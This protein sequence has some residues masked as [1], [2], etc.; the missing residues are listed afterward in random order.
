M[1]NGRRRQGTA[2]LPAWDLDL[3]L[4]QRVHAIL[5]AWLADESTARVLR[6]NVHRDVRWFNREAFEAFAGTSARVA[7]IRA[8]SCRTT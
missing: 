5:G 6:V 1:A 2:A 3:P 8:L 4:E 7:A